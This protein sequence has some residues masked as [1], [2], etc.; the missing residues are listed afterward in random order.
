VAVGRRLKIFSNLLSVSTAS[1]QASMDA[2]FCRLVGIGY[3]RIDN[4]Q[5]DQI[6]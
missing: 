3:F 1:S 6:A 2:R 4:L 5:P